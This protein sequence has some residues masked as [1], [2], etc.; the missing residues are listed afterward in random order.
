MQQKYTTRMLPHLH[1]QQRYVFTDPSI[2]KDDCFI[3]LPKAPGG[4]GHLVL[5]R[6]THIDVTT[7]AV[8]GQGS[9]PRAHMGHSSANDI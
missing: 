5:L 4:S 9:M 7:R 3:T 6:V 2:A 8:K 1:Q